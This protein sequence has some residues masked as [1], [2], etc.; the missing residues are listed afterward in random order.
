[1]ASNRI[2]ILAIDGDLAM[3]RLL[4][5]SLRDSHYKF[6]AAF[7]GKAGIAQ[8]EKTLPDVVTVDLDLP[9]MEGHEVIRQIRQSSDTPIIVVTARNQE[10]DKI[11]ALNGGA[12]DYLAKPLNPDEFLLKVRLALRHHIFAGGKSVVVC[13]DLVID[14]LKQR[15]VVDGTSLYLSPMEYRILGIL[16]GQQGRVLSCQY[17]LQAVGR[18]FTLA[19]EKYIRQYIAQIR[20]KLNGNVLDR[21]INTVPGFGYQLRLQPG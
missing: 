14:L 9:D 21:Y 3:I 2:R 6:Q 18:P 11:M 12:D 10:T 1:M 19:G 20:C 15:V 4:R 16:A 7:N 8:F 5:K 13:G 17:L